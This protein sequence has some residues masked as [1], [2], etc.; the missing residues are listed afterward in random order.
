MALVKYFNY[1]RNPNNTSGLSSKYEPE[2]DEGLK[3]LTDLGDKEAD[4]N[5]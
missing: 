5:D 1:I 3:Y 4:K 2:K